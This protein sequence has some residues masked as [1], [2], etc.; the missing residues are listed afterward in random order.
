MI[1]QLPLQIVGD[2][3]YEV[4][5]GY[6]LNP[7]IAVVRAVDEVLRRLGPL[8]VGLSES[9]P[10]VVIIRLIA[11]ESVEVHSLVDSGENGR[12]PPDA[13]DERLVVVAQD[14]ELRTLGEERSLEVHLR[15]VVGVIAAVAV[16]ENVQQRPV[17]EAFVGIEG[18]HGKRAEVV[19]RLDDIL[20]LAEA[21]LAGKNQ[22]RQTQKLFSHT[23]LFSR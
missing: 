19:A 3:A 14:I 11:V 5:F 16:V 2:G 10:F 15:V 21:E 6:D 7:A 18:H 22:S 17:L 12:R 23:S 8:L 9:H 13:G 4:G 20:F 1:A